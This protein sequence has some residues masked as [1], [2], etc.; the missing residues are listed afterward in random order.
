VIY[1]IQRKQVC[2]RNRRVIA[3]GTGEAIDCPQVSADR[4]SRSLA[5]AGHC[6]LIVLVLPHPRGQRPS[7]D[8]CCSLSLG[9]G[10]QVDVDTG[11]TGR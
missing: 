8:S 2:Q 6:F 4:A 1:T 11:Y 10:D 3:E 9:D 5:T 7:Y